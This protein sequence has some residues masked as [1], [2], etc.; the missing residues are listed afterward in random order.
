MREQ[1]EEM[2][3]DYNDLRRSRSNPVAENT[4]QKHA[5]ETPKVQHPQ[6]KAYQEILTAS[7]QQFQPEEPQQTSFRNYANEPQQTSFRK[8]AND[9]NHTRYQFKTMI[10]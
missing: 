5:F 9:N 4:S 10:N 3:E 6:D 7:K 8:Y 1:M 2:R